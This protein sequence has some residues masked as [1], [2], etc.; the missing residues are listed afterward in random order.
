MLAEC[1]KAYTGE[2]PIYALGVASHSSRIQALETT[3]SAAHAGVLPTC[4]LGL[5]S[6]G[7]RMQAVEAMLFQSHAAP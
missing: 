4:A 3:L 1:S 7:S 6:L 2:S 5:A